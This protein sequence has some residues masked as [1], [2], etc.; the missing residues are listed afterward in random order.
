MLPLG[1]GLVMGS[2]LGLGVAGA[3]PGYKNARSFS[4]ASYE[5]PLPLWD[6]LFSFFWGEGFN[7]RES[8]D[9]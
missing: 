3:H 8:L 1:N 4:G 5:C 6:F 2:C 9:S 7:S